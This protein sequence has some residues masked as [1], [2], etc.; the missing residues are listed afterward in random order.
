MKKLEQC[1]SSGIRLA[2]RH[3][4][5]FVDIT[6][7]EEQGKPQGAWHAGGAN[8]RV[9]VDH[10]DSSQLEDNGMDMKIFKRGSW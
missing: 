4:H 9:E 10:D 5:G 2:I 8:A 3:W 1:W 6:K 7:P